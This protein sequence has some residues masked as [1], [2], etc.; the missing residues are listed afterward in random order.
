MAVRVEQRPERHVRGEPPALGVDE[1][2]QRRGATRPARRFDRLESGEG[3]GQRFRLRAPDA[4]VRHRRCAARRIEIGP[5]GGRQTGDATEGVEVLHHIEVEVEGI[6]AERRQGAVG[7]GLMDRHLRQ[8]QELEDGVAGAG[9][10]AAESRQIAQVPH[11]PVAPTAQ[12]EEREQDPRSPLAHA[13]GTYHRGGTSPR[14][15]RRQRW[16]AR[17]PRDAAGARTR[18]RL[19]APPWIR[20]RC[21]RLPTCS[22]C[23]SGCSG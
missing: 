21:S 10:P 19:D 3:R 11:P 13:A 14:L 2:V 8:R 9:Q 17:F 23:R 22:R 6:E 15:R 7:A 16:T 18:K 20:R 4:G 1:A 5:G 12:A